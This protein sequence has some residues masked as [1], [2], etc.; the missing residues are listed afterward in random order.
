MLQEETIYPGGTP[1]KKEG[2]IR[3]I[4]G[5]KIGGRPLTIG[6]AI[7][8]IMVILLVYV[9]IYLVFNSCTRCTREVESAPTASSPISFYSG[10]NIHGLLWHNVLKKVVIL[11]V[12]HFEMD[13]IVAE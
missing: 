12:F 1:P 8:D 5:T 6:E 10:L 7:V 3:K 4:L 11:P 13:I 9:L 2:F